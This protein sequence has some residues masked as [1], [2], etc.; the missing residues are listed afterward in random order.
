MKQIKRDSFDNYTT[1]KMGSL[2]EAAV[3]IGWIMGCGNEKKL[4]RIKKTAKYFAN[5][6][7]ISE[8]MQNIERDIRN[9]KNGMSYNFV[10]NYGL[11]NG[12]EFFMD[13]KRK[14]IE[15]SMKLDI[16][17]STIKEI[18][19]FIES[20]VDTVIDETSPDIKSNYSSIQTGK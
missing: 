8:D 1:N 19:N 2:G 11:Q 12:Y 4:N 3:C 20:K 16:Y 9:S 13:N 10:L 17:T 18:I 6:Y 15:D 5:F 14:F 7:K